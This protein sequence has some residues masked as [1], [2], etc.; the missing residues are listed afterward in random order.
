[1]TLKPIEVDQWAWDEACAVMN[2]VGW[3]MTSV[4]IACATALMAERE[5]CALH[6]RAAFDDRPRREG[7][8]WNDGFDDGTKAAEAAIRSRK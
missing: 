7:I 3:H 2:K 8:D 1:M 4:R 6:A 5:A